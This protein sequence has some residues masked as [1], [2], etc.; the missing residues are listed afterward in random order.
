MESMIKI[1][2]K[3]LVKVFGSQTQ[4]ALEMFQKGFTKEQILTKT[5]QTIA[6]N[7]ISFSVEDGETFVIM[8]LSG[9]GKST[10][11]RC[12]NRLIEPTS[13]SVLIDGENITKLKPRGLR[14]IR[15]RKMAMVFQ[16]FALLPHRTVLENAVYGLEV[17]GVAK[18][19]RETRADKA[20]ALVGLAGWE[21]SYPD[22]LSGGMKQRVGL[23]R[24][25]TNDPEI[26]LMDEAFSALDPLIRDEMQEELL[27]LQKQMN[28]T[29]VFI[30]HDLSEAL[31]LGDHIAF[32]KDG[33]LVQIGTPEE[34][35]EQPADDY[36][37]KFVNI[38]KKTRGVL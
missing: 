35:T 31:R 28:K 26:L 34:I 1:E 38:I 5:G 7:N 37:A 14:Q 23:A 20:L 11:L 12:L 33:S 8:G 13:G 18:E 3:N 32:V 17:Q 16:Q 10:I 9:C 25:L 15:Q 27:Y 4:K 36:V 29:I 24:A 22:N 6:V 21:N 19:E 30:T 2:V